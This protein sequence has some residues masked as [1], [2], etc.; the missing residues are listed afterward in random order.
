MIRI[1]L[2]QHKRRKKGK[3]VPSFITAGLGLLLLAIIVT[4]YFDYSMKG[5]LSSLAQQKAGND[6]KIAMLQSKIAEVQNFEKLNTKFKERKQIIEQLRQNQALPVKILDEISTR[7][8][9]GVW[10]NSLNISP[11]PALPA[12]VQRGPK[13]A[14]PA[15]GAISDNIQMSGFGYT[16]DDIVQFVQTLKASS[17]F[18]DV[19]LIGTSKTSISG[20]EAYSFSLTMKVKG[21][22]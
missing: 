11:A 16:N 21:N 10:L 7:L 13:T 5:R 22:G 6:N 3:K 17:L 19:Y 9:D 2:L 1:N 12:K 14:Q 15:G 20:V 4:F 8:T 18:T